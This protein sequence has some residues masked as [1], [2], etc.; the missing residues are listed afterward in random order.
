MGV[1]VAQTAPAAA[2]AHTN[3]AKV[4]CHHQRRKTAMTSAMEMTL[5][6][7]SAGLTR[8]GSMD[9]MCVECFAIVYSRVALTTTF[10]GRRAN[11]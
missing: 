6:V 8:P 2:A 5:P 3:P 4:H 7:G 9:A 1:N 11:K 10:L